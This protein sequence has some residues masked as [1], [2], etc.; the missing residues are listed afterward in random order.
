M[1]KKNTCHIYSYLK[2]SAGYV[3]LASLAGITLA[4]IEAITV[5][6]IKIPTSAIGTEK[7]APSSS[8]E[9]SRKINHYCNTPRNI[10]TMIPSKVINEDSIKNCALIIEDLN[11]IAL[12]TPID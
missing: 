10:P 9:I 1:C 4:K 12:S 2:A 8:V 5:T 11:P 6:T 3:L 7:R